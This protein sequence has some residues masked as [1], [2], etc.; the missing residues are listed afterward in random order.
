MSVRRVTVSRDRPVVVRVENRK[1]RN[2]ALFSKAEISKENITPETAGQMRN[3]LARKQLEQADQLRHTLAQAD[4]AAEEALKLTLHAQDRQKRNTRGTGTVSNRTPFY[5]PPN[6]TN[7]DGR[8]GGKPSLRQ[9]PQSTAMTGDLYDPTFTKGMASTADVWGVVDMIPVELED[10]LTD[11]HAKVGHYENKINNLNSTVVDLRDDLDLEREVG[12][13]RDAETL[14]IESDRQRVQAAHTAQVHAA[15]EA[16]AEHHEAM[17]IHAAMGRPMPVGYPYAPRHP[18]PVAVAAAAAAA[19]AGRGGGPAVRVAVAGGVPPAMMNTLAG[20]VRNAQLAELELAQSAEAQGVLADFGRLEAENRALR[21][22]MMKS[23][24]DMEDMQ[25]RVEHTL[26]LQHSF[27]ALRLQM[28]ETKGRLQDELEKKHLEVI[29]KDEEIMQ[30]RA[31]SQIIVQSAADVKAA[32]SNA[33]KQVKRSAA[34]DLAAA[35]AAV[36]SL[37]AANKQQK[38]AF[39]A[40]IKEQKHQLQRVESS[41]QTMG[42]ELLTKEAQIQQIK[43][44]RSGQ[45]QAALTAQLDQANADPSDMAAGFSVLPDSH[46]SSPEPSLSGSFNGGDDHF[47]GEC[48][49]D[50]GADADADA[51]AAGGGGGMKKKGFSAMDRFKKAGNAVK[52]QGRMSSAFAAAGQRRSRKQSLV[53]GTEESLKKSQANMKALNTAVEDG[54]RE[55]ERLETVIANQKAEVASMASKVEGLEGEVTTLKEDLSAVKTER[56]MIT[57]EKE[58]IEAATAAQIEGLNAELKEAEDEQQGRAQEIESLTSQLSAKVKELTE[59]SAQMETMKSKMEEASA[60]Q[61]S[62]NDEIEGL[63]MQLKDAAETAAQK[64][65]LLQSLEANTILLK[66]EIEEQQISAVRVEERARD[67]I[68]RLEVELHKAAEMTESIECLRREEKRTAE[69]RIWDLKEQ[70]DYSNTSR[71]SLQNYVG[72]VKDAYRDVFERP[73]GI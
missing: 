58:R 37:K 23:E 44:Q 62:N 25:K 22:E 70:L 26:T 72:Y 33:V 60:A 27:A 7:N 51:G 53:I 8:K 9:P 56:D 20:R 32:T 45:M 52:M 16:A 42:A 40:Q 29:R 47:P 61:A 14:A 57:K 50:A 64:D 28:K 24:V 66:T 18:I 3:K 63:K 4:R 41:L 31:R 34:V 67:Q 10:H 2:R 30:L 48:S 65:V 5:P 54:K 68:N 43:S 59:A 12:A 17:R 73:G 38:K 35:N 6:K 19:A 13:R 15:D 49:P 39:K 71:R 36:A 69:T 1:G 21:E 46:H 55:G 11:L